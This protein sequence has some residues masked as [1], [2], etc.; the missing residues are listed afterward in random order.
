[1]SS[2]SGHS[3]GQGA[4]APPV[5]DSALFCFGLVARGLR[6]CSVLCCSG[7]TRPP[8]VAACRRGGACML[9]LEALCPGGVLGVVG[10]LS[11]L[12]GSPPTPRASPVV[13]LCTGRPHIEAYSWLHTC[14]SGVG[15]TAV[16]YSYVGL[17]LAIRRFAAHFARS[18]VRA[19][20]TLASDSD[21]SDSPG[22][23][24][25]PFRQPEKLRRRARHPDSASAFFGRQAT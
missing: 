24:R 18:P 21:W 5:A 3:L 2:F 6:R 11:L 14:T 25:R 9:G 17:C 8:C 15:P 22:C 10:S 1:M 20:R 4:S 23:V 7:P 13:P 16:E 12:R 19:S